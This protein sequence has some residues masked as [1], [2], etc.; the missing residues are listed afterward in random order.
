MPR[1]EIGSVETAAGYDSAFVAEFYDHIP[2]YRV[3]GD[4]EFYVNAA[5]RYGPNVLE[6][7]CGTGRILF[8]MA[9]A[10][11]TVTGIDASEAMLDRARRR[12][13]DYPDIVKDRVRSLAR[14][15]MREVGELGQFSLI[16]APFRLFQFLLSVD[17]QLAFLATVRR[18]LDG[19]GRFA[20]DVFDFSLLDMPIVGREFGDESP[21][22]LPDGRTVTRKKMIT[23]WNISAQTLRTQSIFYVESDRA[24]TGQMRLVHEHT[25]RYLFRFELEHLLARAGFVVERLDCDFV[26]TP[27][28]GS[29][30]GE[31]VVVARSSEP[32]SRM[33]ASSDE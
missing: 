20:F 33:G 14:R 25:V 4:V 31:M 10:G 6:L 8:A 21:F 15:D 5:R 24:G 2:R 9:E 32:L 16:A 1:P 29:Y 18:S 12:L 19:G 28:G 13:A 27:Y 22:A 11:A 3:R 30:P 23:D 7:G 17:E 26:G